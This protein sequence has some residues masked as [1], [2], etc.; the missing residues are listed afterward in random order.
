VLLALLLGTLLGGRSD[1]APL[2]ESIAS[3]M[4][5]GT[6][7]RVRFLGLRFSLRAASGRVG[8]R[9]ARVSARSRSKGARFAVTLLG[10]LAKIADACERRPIA[11][12]G[13]G[14]TR[15]AWTGGEGK[16]PRC[17]YRAEARK[18]GDALAKDV[19]SPS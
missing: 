12:A 19:S 5:D 18:G 13:L 11:L 1:S 6:V 2:L 4:D 10:A 3:Q 17:P 7:E 9:P 16:R 15:L 14:T 8:G